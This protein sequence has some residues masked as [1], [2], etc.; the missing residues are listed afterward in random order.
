MTGFL[1]DRLA[2]IRE[3]SGRQAVLWGSAV[4]FGLLAFFPPTESCLAQDASE[5]PVA[6]QP[7]QPEVSRQEWLERVQAAKRRAREVT[8]E[9][10]NHPDADEPTPEDLARVASERVLNDE[11]L[12]PGDIV[13]TNKGLFVF[14]GRTDQHPKSEDFTPLGRR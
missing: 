3:S 2:L 8:L 6:E 5:N 13:A 1:H 11:S 4:L 7:V 14:H 12:Q 10:R 9:K